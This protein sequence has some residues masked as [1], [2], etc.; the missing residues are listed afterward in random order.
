MTAS[1]GSRQLGEHFLDAH[2]ARLLE[3]TAAMARLHACMMSIK[4]MLAKLSTP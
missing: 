1:S 2:H 3:P 4:E